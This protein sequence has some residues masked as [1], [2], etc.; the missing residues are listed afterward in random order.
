MIEALAT[1]GAVTFAVVAAVLWYWASTVSVNAR[2]FDRP[3]DPNHPNDMVQVSDDQGLLI[4]KQIGSKVIDVLETAN[5]Q[6]RWNS[7]AA[8]AAAISAG[9]QAVA[10]IA[11]QAGM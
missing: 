2:P 10:L 8:L 1:W 4:T 9:M 5:A 3:F 6:S 11:H 7:Y